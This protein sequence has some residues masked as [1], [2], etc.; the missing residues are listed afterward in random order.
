MIKL[1]RITKIKYSKSIMIFMLKL[2]SLT[3][4]CKALCFS[5]GVDCLKLPITVEEW[6]VIS[7]KLKVGGIYLIV[8]GHWMVNM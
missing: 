8:S 7:T 1:F 3:N 5:L 6:E 2:I 4:T